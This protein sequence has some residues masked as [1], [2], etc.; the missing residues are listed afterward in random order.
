MKSF[1]TGE[2]HTHADMIDLP[3]HLGPR[4][5]DE[6]AANANHI[7]VD[8]RFGSEFYITQHRDDLAPDACIDIAVTQNRDNH[9]AHA[10]AGNA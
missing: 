3:I 10:T 7:A 5:A 1:E 2:I 9:I 6:R 4:I 8:H